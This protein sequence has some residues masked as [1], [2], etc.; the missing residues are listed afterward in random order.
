MINVW[1]ITSE[2]PLTPFAPVYSHYICTADLSKLIDFK[3]IK[4]TILGKEKAIIR[5]YDA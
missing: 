1:Q 2:D 4:Y 5:E 3:D